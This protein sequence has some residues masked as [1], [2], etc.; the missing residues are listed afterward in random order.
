[1][2][3][4]GLSTIP[5]NILS[6]VEKRAKKSC[7]WGNFLEDWSPLTADVAENVRAMKNAGLSWLKSQTNKD[8][9]W[10]GGDTATAIIALAV[11]QDGW[12]QE[13]DLRSRLSA[14]RLEIELLEKLV[15]YAKFNFIS[16]LHT[17]PAPIVFR[18]CHNRHQHI[19]L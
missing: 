16:I 10:D 17:R 2:L 1:M 6:F 12:P 19:T 14:K 9:G 15:R 4:L 3:L 8:F 18:L 13:N 11:A 5:H 7:P